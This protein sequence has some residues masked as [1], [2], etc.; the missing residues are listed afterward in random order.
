MSRGLRCGER[1]RRSVVITGGLET[2]M[3]RPDAFIGMECWLLTIYSLKRILSTKF[4]AKEHSN[5]KEL[6]VTY[7]KR[8]YVDE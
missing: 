7:K 8:Q 5:S 3:I 1:V 4:V 2:A 6:N